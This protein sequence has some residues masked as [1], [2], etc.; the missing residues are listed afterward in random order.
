MTGRGAGDPA[1]G[2]P[3]EFEL[4]LVA[5]DIDGTLLLDWQPISTTTIDAIHRCRAADIPFVLVT[6]RPIRWLAP[7]AEQIPDLGL[8]VCLNGAVIYDI[9]ASRVVEAHTIAD[10]DV[11]EIVSAVTESQPQAR[12]AYETL[13]GLLIDPGF[14]TRFPLDAVVVDDLSQV[15]ERDVVKILVSIGTDDSQ[16]LH[17]LL[18]PVLSHSCHATFSDPVNGL[19]ELAPAGITKAK[20]LAQLCERLGVDR[21]RVMA[22]GDM[23][24]DIEMLTWAGHGVAVGNALETVKES[25]DAVAEA[26]EAE[27]VARYLGAVLDTLEPKASHRR[28]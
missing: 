26:V 8:V 4:G 3:P 23:P 11:T 6:G 25:A 9:A 24:N 7:I 17:D 20:T 1:V 28:G 18:G 27:G 2:V 21:H 15:R 12:F 22:F 19:V 14:P 13:S 5:S 10:S 16:A